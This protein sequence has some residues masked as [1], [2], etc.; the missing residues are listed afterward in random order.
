MEETTHEDFDISK[1]KPDK[2][3]RQSKRTH[4]NTAPS[5]EGNILKEDPCPDIVSEKE[6]DLFHKRCMKKSD[7]E[8]K[9]DHMTSIFG[10]NNG[11]KYSRS[12]KNKFRSSSAPVE[13]F[14][15]NVPDFYSLPMFGNSGNSR[16][17]SWNNE[18][19]EKKEEDDCKTKGIIELTSDDNYLN[20]EIT[21]DKDFRKNQENHILKHATESVSSR[22]LRIFRYIKQ[23]KEIPLDFVRLESEFNQRPKK[24]AK[25]SEKCVQSH[26]AIVDDMCEIVIG[27]GG[28]GGHSMEYCQRRVRQGKYVKSDFSRVSREEIKSKPN[29]SAP[30]SFNRIYHSDSTQNSMKNSPNKTKQNYSDNFAMVHGQNKFQWLE[31]ADKPIVPLDSS[32]QRNFPDD[33]LSHHFETTHRKLSYYG[34]YKYRNSSKDVEYVGI[35]VVLGNGKTKLKSDFAKDTQESAP[36][37]E[38]YDFTSFHSQNESSQKRYEQDFVKTEQGSDIGAEIQN[39]SDLDYSPSQIVFDNIGRDNFQYMDHEDKKTDKDTVYSERVRNLPFQ[40]GRILQGKPWKYEL[41]NPELSWSDTERTSSSQS[42]LKVRYAQ[43]RCLLM[44]YQKWLQLGRARDLEKKHSLRK[45]L[46]ALRQ[47]ALK[48][49]LVSESLQ[50]RTNCLR[51][52]SCL[53]KWEVKTRKCLRE[54]LSWALYL[55]HQNATLMKRMRTLRHL[56]RRNLIRVCLHVWQA[57]SEDS[58]RQSRGDQHY[59]KQLASMIWKRWR[60]YHTHTLTLTTM[61]TT[62]RCLHRHLCLTIMFHRLCT[63]YKNHLKSMHH[64]RCHIMRKVLHQ[65]RRSTHVSLS[66]CRHIVLSVEQSCD[67]SRMRMVLR[68]WLKQVWVVTW[69]QQ[70]DQWILRRFLVRWQKRWLQKARREQ[71]ILE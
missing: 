69:N 8:T 3:K 53:N 52:R 40:T 4:S 59:R 32:L 9:S 37:L 47:A 2:Y 57:R 25:E 14:Q 48:R 71:H 70:A 64:Y 6:Q 41:E 5:N 35:S 66:E 26:H 68:Y 61:A 30:Q 20:S 65:W 27:G 13:Q 60:C 11:D 7:H 31:P 23:N 33:T 18:K 17:S 43:R 44:W 1:T 34:E 45:G 29:S 38:L 58:Q 28:G 46:H 21:T 12:D 10:N 39:S 16:L 51:L 62:V 19:Y 55:W 67:R 54:R 15:T 24:A 50:E 22:Y 42:L 36:N 49:R 63:A 56:H